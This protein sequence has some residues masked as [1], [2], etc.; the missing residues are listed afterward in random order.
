MQKQMNLAGIWSLQLDAEPCQYTAPPQDYALTMTLPGTT[1]QQAIGSLNEK[2]EDGFLTERYPFA[3]QIWL[4]KIVTLEPEQVGQPCF[5]YLE[6]TR[7]TRLWVN[8]KE[9][10]EE[11]SLCTPH[12][13]DLSAHTAETMELVLCIKNVDYPTKGGHMTSPDTQTN[14]IGVTGEL[15]LQFHAPVYLSDVQA[16]PCAELKSV[17]LKAVLH[18]AASVQ[19]QI[20][21]QNRPDAAWTETLTADGDGK[22]AVTLQLPEDTPLWSEFT[23]EIVTL[24][25]TLPEQETQTVTFGLRAFCAQTDHFTINGIPTMLRGKH[26]GL[27]FPL[28]GAAPT[29]VEEWKRVLLLMKDWGINHYRFHTCC[30]PEACF[31][32]ADAVG[33][34]LEPELPFWGTIYGEEQHPEEYAAQ[35]E[36]QEY[37]IREGFRIAKAFGNHPSFCMFSLGNEL[38]GDPERLDA[39]LVQLRA[40]DDRMLYTQGSNNFQHMPVTVPHEDFWTGVRMGGGKLI[41][42]SYA[43]CDAP[44]GRLQTDAPSAN[45]DYEQ[46]LCPSES[47]SANT[48]SGE[49]TELQIQYGTGI[50]TV[51]A[52]STDGLVPHKPIVTHEIGQYAVYPDFSEISHYTG[53]VE[54]RNFEIFRE[55]LAAAGMGAQAEDFFRC[56]GA[57]S[58]DCY[59]MEL[60]AAMRS[61]HIA[62]FQ[63]LDLQDFPGQGT[64]LVGMLNALLENKGFISA[65]DWRGFCGDLVLLARFDR[66]VWESGAEVPVTIAVRCHRP[67]PA[68]QTI[69]L[70][71][72]ADG[73]TIAESMLS[74]PENCMGYA[75]IGTISL[76]LPLDL[77]GNAELRLEAVAAGVQ[78]RW[79]I[80]ILP[81]VQPVAWERDGVSIVHTITDAMP[82]LQ[83]GKRVLLLPSEVKQAIPGFY[84]ADFWN[85]HMFRLISESIGKEVPVGT[86]GLCIQAEH[87]IA[88]RMYSAEYSTPVW[89]DAV[90]HADCAV[91]D[92]MPEGYRPVVQ[93]IDNWERNHRLGLLFETN[94]AG[95]SLLVCTIRLEEIQDTL[96]GNR[97]AHAVLD[98]CSSDAFCPE[99]RLNVADLTNL[100]G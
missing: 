72:I 30:P 43:T 17:T 23:P 15:A 92:A 61:P 96:S 1:A 47:E 29:D 60:E 56:S 6:R 13:Y 75:E 2:R 21:M 16:Y 27:V 94:V 46:Y 98:Y 70:T 24:C 49:E 28:S 8:G 67:N 71:L 82:L 37:L 12:V 53:V 22:I 36:E 9:I 99:I 18:G 5:L 48:A 39:I 58:R 54:A 83:Q 64:A 3:G 68:Q 73:E 66:Y 14:W 77:V 79:A 84:C 7:M 63:I 76:Q 19:V 86:M 91:L 89:Y 90:S 38:W 32:A 88:K 95:G 26:D 34:Y 33:I 51:K 20:T 78:N 93:M 45:W 100:F 62:G 80:T 69:R 35:K 55:R 52:T 11:K 41:R 81:P 50:K 42:G 65:E 40:A 31:A 74:M 85:Y 57:L 25:L 4:K 97:L 10:G 59:Q 44:I 87:P